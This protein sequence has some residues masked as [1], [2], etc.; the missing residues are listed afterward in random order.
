MTYSIKNSDGSTLI[1]INDGT[2]DTTATSLTL[3]GKNATNYGQYFNQNFVNLLQNFANSTAPNY[4]IAGQ[5]WYDTANARLKVYDAVAKT[6]KVAAGTIVS[7]TDPGTVQ[8]DI[9]IDSYRKQVYV[10]D[11]SGE[12]LVGPQYTNQQG[13]S[14]FEVTDIID[15][16]N[17]SHTVVE[18]YVAGVLIGI[19]SKDA[20]SPLNPVSGFTGSIGV[21]FNASSYSTFSSTLTTINATGDGTTAT[22][23]FATQ[24]TVPFSVG[25]LITVQGI[26]PSGY[27]GSWVVVNCTT[28]SVSFASSITTSQITAGTVTG[29]ITTSGIVFNTLASSALSLVGVDGVSRFTASSF[30]TTTADSTMFSQLKMYSTNPLILGP[31]GNVQI[32]VSNTLFA[33]KPATS[34]N[35]VQ[36][37]AVIT[38]TVNGPQNSFYIQAATQNVGLSTN[39]PQ[40]TLDV[41]GTMRINSLTPASSTDAGVTGQIAWD[42]NYLY[43]CTAGGT[44]GQGTWKRVQLQSF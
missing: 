2:L 1:A 16:N 27:N 26:N 19:F 28:S 23:T 11:G 3:V 30:V 5:L 35:T 14:G 7:N 34:S 21:G 15:S 33:I 8:G 44:T 39:T 40:A 38:N 32:S 42:A 37:F 4:P 43:V 9:W 41:N 36:D 10:N 25:S 24:P 17:V 22:L 20:F 6:F 29:G 31:N 12:F 18:M 13:L